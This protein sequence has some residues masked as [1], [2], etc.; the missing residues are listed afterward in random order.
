MFYFKDFDSRCLIENILGD[1][2]LIVKFYCRFYMDQPTLFS[3]E[4]S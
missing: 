3:S 2:L 4:L 1:I